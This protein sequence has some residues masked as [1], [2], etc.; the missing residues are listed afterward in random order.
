MGVKSRGF[1]VA[2]FRAK[3]DHS[4]DNYLI[5]EPPT[6]DLFSLNR[7]RR[8]APTDIECTPYK[9]GLATIN[10]K[11]F[12]NFDEDYELSLCNYPSYLNPPE[13]NY[14][15]IV[16]GTLTQLL[17]FQCSTS[18][19]VDMPIIG[20]YETDQ[21]FLLTYSLTNSPMVT[22]TGPTTTT[23]PRTTTTTTTTTTT[24]PIVPTTSHHYDA[25]T[26]PPPPPPTTTKTVPTTTSRPT[27]TTR[28]QTTSS[29][30][31]ATVRISAMTLICTLFL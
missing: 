5:I 14:C 26:L 12:P 17:T 8:D 16:N 23:T 21:G 28:P 22:T 9:K 15:T 6:N 29:G 30:F 13:N 24:V 19:I 18:L 11:V 25:P 2:S 1:G 31:T 10:M 3:E 20:K 27:T 7:F 4:R